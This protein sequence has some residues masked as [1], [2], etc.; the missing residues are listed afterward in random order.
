MASG[1]S[2]VHFH[3]RLMLIEELIEHWKS[4]EEVG[5]VGLDEG[6]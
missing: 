5:L 3:R 2:H 6:M 4:G 1:A